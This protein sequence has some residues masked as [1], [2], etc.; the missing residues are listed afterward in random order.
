MD[1]IEAYEHELKKYAVEK[2]QETGCVTIYN[3]TSEGG[4]VTFNINGVFAQD[5]ATY[6]NSKGI[7]CRSGQHCAKILI[8]F[9]G[10]VAT[11]RASFYFYTTKEDIDAL[12]EAV[13]TAKEEYLNAYFI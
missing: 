11:I 5:G 7:A 6:L 2:L 1:N 3:A 4:I 9:L 8:D 13:K 12:V 10:T